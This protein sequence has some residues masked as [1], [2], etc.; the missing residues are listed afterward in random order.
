MVKA[1]GAVRVV[2]QTFF[3]LFS[4]A[5]NMKMSF[6]KEDFTVVIIIINMHSN[7]H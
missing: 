5:Q 1:V 3:F 7:V 2:G 4:E 6:Y